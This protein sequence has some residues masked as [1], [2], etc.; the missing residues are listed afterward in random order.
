MVLSAALSRAG[1]YGAH[2]TWPR[3]VHVQ[4]CCSGAEGGYSGVGTNALR[5]VALNTGAEQLVS[6]F[7][8]IRL[9]EPLV[10][11]TWGGC[12]F[13]VATAFKRKLLNK[14]PSVPLSVEL[15]ALESQGADEPFN[16]ARGEPW[17]PGGR[18]AL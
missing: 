1:R 3:D 15:P 10:L 16:V 7:D 2:N 14:I 5:A 8:N 4:E 6:Q 12:I 18:E 17:G 11:L 13:L 9:S